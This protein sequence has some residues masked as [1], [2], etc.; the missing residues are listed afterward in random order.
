MFML[1][2]TGKSLWFGFSSLPIAR[3]EQGTMLVT[4]NSNPY[5]LGTTASAE[6]KTRPTAWMI[7][8]GITMLL[9]A[10]LC[11]A[12]TVFGLMWSFDTVATSSSTT[13]TTVLANGIT[14]SV[15]PIFAGAPLAVIG[16]ILIIL[17]FMLRQPVT[18]RHD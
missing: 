5:Q 1:S 15:I 13:E 4:M 18:T 9:L 10:G 14:L 11:L 12:I 7:W 6:T 3:T 17:G 2:Y 8:T 16:V